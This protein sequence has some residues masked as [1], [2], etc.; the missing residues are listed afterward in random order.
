MNVHGTVHHTRA[1]R[2]GGRPPSVH[3]Q[4]IKGEDIT[5]YGQ[6]QQTRSF[7]FVDDL[8]DGLIRLMEADGLTGPVNLGNPHERTICE[9]AQH[10]ISLTGSDSQLVYRPLPPDDPKQ[11]RP[12]ISLATQRL[13]WSPEVTLEDGLQS[14][15]DYFRGLDLTQWT[16]PTPFWEAPPQR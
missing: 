16:P 11:R 8:V 5:I 9:L 10:I 15:I 2:V 3:S 12:D 6:G 7:C 1:P 13:G 14:T 4:A